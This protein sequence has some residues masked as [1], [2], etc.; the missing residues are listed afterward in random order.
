[1]RRKTDVTFATNPEIYYQDVFPHS[2][3]IAKKVKG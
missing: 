3:K 2:N 1:M